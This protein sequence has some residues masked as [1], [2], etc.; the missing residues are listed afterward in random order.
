MWEQL[1]GDACNLS[2][3]SLSNSESINKKYKKFRVVSE[4]RQHPSSFPS[5]TTI[6]TFYDTLKSRVHSFVSSDFHF[7]GVHFYWSM[8]PKKFFLI[9][10]ESSCE[11]VKQIFASTNQITVFWI[12]PLVILGVIIR[13]CLLIVFNPLTFQCVIFYT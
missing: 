3:R 1:A 12:L 5:L 10:S 11:N 4:W 2:T 6:L 7:C 8:Y 9:S 13:F